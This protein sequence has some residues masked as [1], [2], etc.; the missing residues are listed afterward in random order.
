MISAFFFLVFS[1]DVTSDHSSE[2]IRY[3]VSVISPGAPGNA[4]SANHPK[5]PLFFDL[6]TTPDERHRRFQPTSTN[7]H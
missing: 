7:V 1:A 2:T 3:E 5:G 6:K 4:V